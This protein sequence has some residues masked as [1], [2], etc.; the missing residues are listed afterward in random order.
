MVLTRLG[1]MW[2]APA[3]AFSPMIRLASGGVFLSGEGDRG[4]GTVALRPSLGDGAGG[5]R[6]AEV[7][8]TVTGTRV[9]ATMAPPPPI[10]A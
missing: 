2:P 9:G 5:T 4:V 3:Y 10:G 1:L 7:R 6:P 8:S